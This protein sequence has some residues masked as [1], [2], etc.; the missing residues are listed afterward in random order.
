MLGKTNFG[1]MYKMI[2]VGLATGTTSTTAIGL[3]E[4]LNTNSN[5]SLSGNT[6]S[7]LIPGVYEIIGDATVTSTTSG[8]TGLGVYVDGTSSASGVFDATGASETNSIMVYDVI[9]VTN[10]TSGYVAVTIMPVNAP[11]IVSG[12]VS[13]KKIY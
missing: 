7:I 2:V 8:E 9:D 13:I 3:S 12:S 5:V 1:G 10:A 4:V 6:V 11:T